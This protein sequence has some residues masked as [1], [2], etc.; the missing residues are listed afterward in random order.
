MAADG[1]YDH[2]KAGSF[3]WL[4]IKISKEIDAWQPD[5]ENDYTTIEFQDE[6]YDVYVE[7]SVG[8]W[9]E[10]YEYLYVHKVKYIGWT[11]SIDQ[12][13]VGYL[14]EEDEEMGRRLD[15]ALTKKYE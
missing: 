1:K 12:V 11:I 6:G 15:E 3:D 10:E 4:M 5:N 2:D 13:S 7:I 8:K 14:D 9:E